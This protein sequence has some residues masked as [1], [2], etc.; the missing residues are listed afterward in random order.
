MINGIP[1]TTQHN[2]YHMTELQTSLL[3]WWWWRYRYFW[4]AKYLLTV[5]T[6]ATRN[7]TRY[8]DSFPLPYPNPTRSQKALLVNLCLHPHQYLN[9]FQHKRNWN[10]IQG[11]DC[12]VKASAHSGVVMVKFCSEIVFCSC[13]SLTVLEGLRLLWLQCQIWRYY[14]LLNS[15]GKKFRTHGLL[16]EPKY[17]KNS[18]VTFMCSFIWKID[19]KQSRR[20]HQ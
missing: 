12:N 17:S 20:W 9:V 15:V 18:W 2:N 6:Y 13:L 1:T 5:A 10:T 4:Y 8:P 11:T 3:W 16:L 14:I 7:P 19:F